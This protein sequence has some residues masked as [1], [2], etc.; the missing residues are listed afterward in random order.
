MKDFWVERANKTA[1]HCKSSHSVNH[2]GAL[3]L[4]IGWVQPAIPL[5]I[6]FAVGLIL[7]ARLIQLFFRRKSLISENSVQGTHWDAFA[8]NTSNDTVSQKVAIN[9][10]PV[11]FTKNQTGGTKA[12]NQRLEKYLPKAIRMAEGSHYDNDFDL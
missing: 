2:K 8:S 9:H 6:V 4:V 3:A 10:S 5:L 1:P 11:W 7:G 12:S